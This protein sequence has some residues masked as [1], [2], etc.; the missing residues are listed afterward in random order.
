MT[1]RKLTMCSKYQRDRKQVKLQS[2][3]CKL[4]LI[5]II[6][7]HTVFVDNAK[8]S[9]LIRFKVSIRYIFKFKKVVRS[10]LLKNIMLPKSYLQFSK[11]QWNYVVNTLAI[12]RK[13]LQQK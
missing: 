4:D 6:R 12:Q 13:L 11:N 1:K 8:F 2:Y 7:K 5:Q 9:H 3:I 10:L